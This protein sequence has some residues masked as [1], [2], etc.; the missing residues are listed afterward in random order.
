MKH[1]I[2][3][4]KK[5]LFLIFSCTLAQFYFQSLF[6]QDT[7]FLYPILDIEYR[8]LHQEFEFFRFKEVR[9]K[10]D[11]TKRI[12]A[13]FPNGDYMQ[14]KWKR[15]LPGGDKFNNRPRYEIAAYEFQKLFL[16]PDEYVVPPTVGKGYPL[17]EVLQL[18][19]RAYATFKNPDIVFV[20]LQY[21]LEEVTVE[22]IHDKKRLKQDTL[23]AKHFAIMNIFTYLIR[24]RDS[25][26]G[27]V[28]ISKNR[29]NP[30]LFV[31]D[32]GIAFASEKSRRG[33]KWN[34]LHV[35]RVP[36][37]IINKLRLIELDDLQQKLGVVAQYE[38]INGSF[39]NVEPT[40]NIDPKK[41][42]RRLENTIQF[43]LKAREISDIHKR[44]NTLIEMVDSGKIKTF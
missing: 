1:K 17:K 8:L 14:I 25:N 41:G 10:G 43:G 20:V 36:A 3:H 19:L 38:I 5:N 26:K 24:H 4:F 11:I 7:N 29:S 6:A 22:K 44:I 42:I 34:K 18:E 32:N 40:Q 13:K 2:T 28:L 35:K 16:D 30:R 12:I 31:V 37:K 39:K 23:Y 27:N 15:A 9:F 33:D 21:W